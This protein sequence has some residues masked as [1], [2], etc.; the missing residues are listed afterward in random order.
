MEQDRGLRGIIEILNLEH[1]RVEH[2]GSLGQAELEPGEVGRIVQGPLRGV[3]PVPLL[4]RQTAGDGKP[5]PV[6][7]EVGG[8]IGRNVE[9]LDTGDDYKERPEHG[10]ISVNSDDDV[11]LVDVPVALHDIPD[12]L[13][14][15]L[16]VSRRHF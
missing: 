16:L 3:L 14:E 6:N 5:V 7:L 2:L 12:Q 10:E 4:V 13:R 9:G 1:L 11:T 8:L 15:K